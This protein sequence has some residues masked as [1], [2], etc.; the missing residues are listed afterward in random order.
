[1]T[2]IILEEILEE[3]ELLNEFKLMIERTIEEAEEAEKEELKKELKKYYNIIIWGAKMNIEEKLIEKIY[4]LNEDDFLFGIKFL[5]YA[6]I[7][8]LYYFVMTK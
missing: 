1:M 3:S 2:K 5:I 4:K 7:L 6:S 8:L